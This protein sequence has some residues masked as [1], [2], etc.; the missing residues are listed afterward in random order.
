MPV[1]PAILAALVIMGVAPAP[2]V[3]EHPE[4][5]AS[6]PVAR[7]GERTIS[8]AMLDDAIS[9]ALNASYHHGQI[10]GE[11]RRE[12]ER[13][14]IDELIRRELN[15]AGALDR[16]L[17]PPL[18]EAEASRAGIEARLGTAA[19]DEA[20]ASIGMT[21]EDHARAIAETLLAQRAYDEFVLRPA[22]VDDDEVR[23]AFDAAPDQWRMPE[24]SHVLHILLMVRPDANAAETA[25]VERQ[26]AE[27]AA[28]AREGENFQNLASGFSQDMY[29]IKGGDLGWVHR[30]RLVAELED[31]V[32][33]A[34][35]GVV[36]GPVR[37]GEGYHLAKVLGRRQARPMEWSEVEPML[38][39]RLETEKLEVAEDAWFEPLRRAHPVVILDPDLATEME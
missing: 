33:A 39:E 22:E 7:V 18:A 3:S 12:L 19:Y 13:V 37:S 32:W 6:D 21:R 25:G 26:A 34:E 15:L 38:R 5:T 35:I 23:A 28:R 4:L 20:L 10:T 24:S 31:A 30:G 29:R 11:R 36:V 27:L 16:D 8:R 1:T 17:E 9:Q 14:K 2:G